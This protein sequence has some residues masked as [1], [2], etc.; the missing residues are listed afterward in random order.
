MKNPENV[1][2][3][4][5]EKAFVDN[6]CMYTG[7]NCLAEAITM[8]EPVYNTGIDIKDGD[9]EPETDRNHCICGHSIQN[10]FFVLN[11]RSNKYLPIGSD[12]IF[13]FTSKLESSG[14]AEWYP[15]ICYA[16]AVNVMIKKLQEFSMDPD[17]ITNLRRHKSFL[18]A[19]DELAS[20]CSM[21][22]RSFAIERDIKSLYFVNLLNLKFLIGC[23][24]VLG[25]NV[26]FSVAKEYFCN[27]TYYYDDKKLETKY[28]NN[29][30]R[31]YLSFINGSR[32]ERIQWRAAIG[33]IENDRWF[34]KFGLSEK[35]D[36]PNGTK[37]HALQ[38]IKYT[39]IEFFKSLPI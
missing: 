38:Y 15:Y 6:L 31:I 21:P 29:V 16:D 9:L 5:P 30:K 7:T 3:N 12:C 34:F 33:K 1:K 18:A 20:R 28:R 2:L 37:L 19:Y 8:I 26:D 4:G 22:S 13:K 36:Y 14:N 35:I 25:V 24:S 10:V 11:R 39:D 17:K 23:A 27:Q 32:E